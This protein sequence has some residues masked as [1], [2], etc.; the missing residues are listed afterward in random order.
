MEL[1]DILAL[2][3]RFDASSAAS[4]KLRLGELR[5]ELSF[6]QVD[7]ELLDLVEQL[8]HLFLAAAEL[9]GPLAVLP[10]ALL[11]PIHQGEQRRLCLPLGRPLALGGRAGGVQRFVLLVHKAALLS[12]CFGFPS[13]HPGGTKNFRAGRKTQK[14]LGASMWYHGSE[15]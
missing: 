13:Y 1:S 10:G 4:L 15:S 12:F 7:L 3:D 14:F 2:L 5:L 8:H 11:L 6:H 9:R